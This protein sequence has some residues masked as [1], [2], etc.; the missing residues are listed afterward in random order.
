MSNTVC[1]LVCV[2]LLQCKDRSLYRFNNRCRIIVNM[3]SAGENTWVIHSSLALSEAFLAILS[4][5]YQGFKLSIEIE[6]IPLNNN[7]IYRVYIQWMSPSKLEIYK[8]IARSNT[9]FKVKK[10]TVKQC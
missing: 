2:Y 6:L 8:F 1:S 10:I 3:S 9:E 5:E 7:N 4:Y